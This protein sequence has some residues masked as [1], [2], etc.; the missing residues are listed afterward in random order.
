MSPTNGRP[1]DVQ[2]FE[3]LEGRLKVSTR[4]YPTDR[5]QVSAEFVEGVLI[6]YTMTSN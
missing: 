1:Y 4:V 6:R 2:Y 3:R 5:G